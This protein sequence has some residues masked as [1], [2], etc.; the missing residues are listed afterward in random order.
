MT[1]KIGSNP[2]PWTYC[3]R[4]EYDKYD[5]NSAMPVSIRFLNIDYQFGTS[6]PYL[7]EIYEFN[8]SEEVKNQ[9]K[10][11]SAKNEVS[12]QR[13]ATY[14][15]PNKTERKGLVTTRVGQGPYR[16][17][18]ISKWNCE[19]AITGINN[20]SIL[21]A[22]HIKRW[23]DSNSDERLDVDNG[24]LLSPNFDALFD[25]HL[26]SFDDDGFVLVNNT[27]IGISNCELIGMNKFGE[28]AGKK[29]K[30]N[31]N[32]GMKKYLKEHRKIFRDKL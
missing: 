17:D 24:I 22:S 32:E 7:R 6:N 23:K 14:K 11:I 5:K 27:S 29:I 28:I 13:R 2:A 3:G 21:I 1:K 12:P 18:L 8:P 15:K 10:S 31:V 25:R 20:K 9:K 4:I 26:I 16:E 30:I 19:C